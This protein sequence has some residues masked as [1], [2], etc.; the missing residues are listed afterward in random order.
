MSI[1]TPQYERH[2][3]HGQDLVEVTGSFAV[4]TDGTVSAVKG[5]G[6]SVARTSAG[7]FSITLDRIYP[8]LVCGS[9]VW[10]GAFYDGGCQPVGYNTTTGVYTVRTYDEDAA[11][12]RTNVDPA[13]AGRIN[14]RLSLTKYNA[15][16]TP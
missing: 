12:V 15:Q 5:R 7:L 3:G 2:A 11:G 1:N 6:F 13:V 9:A 10:E 14:I 16:V 8:E 4:A